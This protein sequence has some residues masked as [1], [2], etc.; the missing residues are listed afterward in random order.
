[1][2]STPD[3]G[4]GQHPSEP[5]QRDEP[6][7][8]TK[9]P[10]DGPG[11][12]PGTD[13]PL[14]FDPYRFGAPEHPVPPEYA[15]PGYRP[16]AA[17]PPP[18]VQPNQAPGSYPPFG[19]QPYPQPYAQQYPQQYPQYPPQQPGVPPPPPGYPPYVAHRPGHGKAVA[20][21]VLGIA[22]IALCW[23]SIFD[24]IPVLLAVIF[25]V[26]ALNEMRARPQAGPNS[27]RRLAIAGIA[28]AVV[29]A[30]LAVSLTVFLYNRFKDCLDYPTGSQEYRTCITD[31]L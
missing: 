16:P 7:S 24:A 15:P 12:G 6:V 20:S 25:G 10:A 14:D 17:A 5:P 4:A 28:C 31:H 18:P 2:S 13:A 30:I 27:G 9:A 21:L 22:S 3:D 26:I 11:T 19:Q 8:F 29:G 1:M 23:L